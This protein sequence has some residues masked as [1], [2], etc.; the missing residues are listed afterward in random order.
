MSI[1]HL[2]AKE[3]T[4]NRLTLLKQLGRNF[5]S[6]LVQD[7][8]FFK[9]ASAPIAG[10]LLVTARVIISLKS[11]RDAEQTYG[12]NDERTQYIHEQA[13]MTITRETAGLGLSYGLMNLLNIVLDGPSQKLFG[14]RVDKP[15]VTGPVKALNHFVLILAGTKKSIAIAPE[16][17]GVE[18]TIRPLE[19]MGQKPNGLQ[20]FM[21]HALKPFSKGADLQGLSGQA[22]HIETLK[23]GMKNFKNLGVP[24]FGTGVSI[25]LAGWVLERTALL[26]TDK[27]IDS[28]K[29]RY[30]KHKQHA[31]TRRAHHQFSKKQIEQN[32]DT[33]ESPSSFLLKATPRSACASPRLPL[34]LVPMSVLF[35]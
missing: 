35:K 29:Q 6:S 24:L 9:I 31:M 11:A 28:M 2:Q 26:K 17:L 25:Y 15:D 1:K 21:R 13:L 8:S 12:D 22:R 4:G 33:D 19:E 23:Q 18:T 30:E 5:G 27:I 10:M 16:A 34:K 20:T 3:I 7:T 32:K 14:M